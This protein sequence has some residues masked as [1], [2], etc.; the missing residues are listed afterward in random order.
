MTE[1][2]SKRILILGGG[3]AGLYAAMQL[4]KTLARDA[5]VEVTLVNRENFFLFTPMLHEVAASDLDLTTI[6]N[7]VGRMLRR[8]NFFAGD[9]ESID[10]PNKRVDVS[11][12]FDHHGHTL[13]YDFLVLGLGSVTNFYNLPGLEQRALT[14]KSLGDAMTLRNRLIAHLEE[15]DSDCC[16][17][18]EPLLTFVVAG[19]GF[20]GVET[21]GGVNDFLR[22]AL[23]SILAPPGAVVTRRAG[24]SRAC[25][26]AGARRE[27]RSLRAGEA[28][29]TKSGGSRQ[30]QGHRC[31]Q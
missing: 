13:Q 16:R 8:V 14:M 10:L 5:D 4:E 25:Y 3:F 20:A 19:G 9:M 31:L 30:Y 22:A 26:P 27:T 15:A 17:E 28:R 1:R 18:K 29:G 24:S 21:V 11:H 2:P 23:P 6:V 12:G 7:P